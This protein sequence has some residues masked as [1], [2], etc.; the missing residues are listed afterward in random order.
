M[1]MTLPIEEMTVGDKIQV[2]EVIWLSLRQNPSEMES[3]A[4]HKDVL[5]ARE[6]RMAD[7]TSRYEDWNEA[8]R[9]IRATLQP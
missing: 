7:G 3:P 9:D 4:W 6:K 8:K 5:A 1:T 2:M